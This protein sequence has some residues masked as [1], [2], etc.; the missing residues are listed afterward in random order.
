[1]PLP[2]GDPHPLDLDRLRPFLAVA[3][4]EDGV[5]RAV[6]SDGWRRIRIDIGRGTLAGPGAITL[7][8]HIAGLASAEPQA[9]AL[10]RLLDVYRR[11][12]FRSCLY[13]DEKRALRWIALLQVSDAMRAGA[14]QREI[15]EVIFG[16][17]RVA[18]EWRGRSDSLRSRVRRLVRDMRAMAQGG[19][20]ALLRRSPG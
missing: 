15:A 10:L 4:G 8:Y 1:V 5:E 11:G 2:A 3:R 14:C 18:D 7:R 13:P 19:W 20:R 17:D 6:L 16:P 12:R 9:A